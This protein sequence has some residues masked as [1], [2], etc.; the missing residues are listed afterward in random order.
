MSNSPLQFKLVSSLQK[1]FSK[2]TPKEMLKR[3]FSVLRGEC[4]SFQIAYFSKAL[5]YSLEDYPVS[6]E[7]QGD[8][9]KDFVYHIVSEVPSH[10]PVHALEDIDDNYLKTEVGLYPDALIP[11]SPRFGKAEGIKDGQCLKLTAPFQHW[12]S[13]WFELPVGEQK[14]GEHSL[15]L[16][17]KDKEQKII[18]QDTLVL[19]IIDKKLVDLDIVHTEW[20]HSDCLADYYEV[21][22]F[23]ERHWEII[24]NYMKTAA[25]HGINAVLTPIFTL[26]LDTQVGGERTTH[27]L[28]EVT[29]K[30]SGYH[31]D[32]SKLDR[33]TDLALRCGIKY[34][35][36]AHLFTQWGAKAAPK[37][38]A[39]VDGQI[40]KIF[41]WETPATS[42]EY[43]A[44]LRALLTDLKRWIIERG[45]EKRVIF[46]I[47]DEP[48]ENDK[49]CY[50]AAKNSVLDIIS[51]FFITD[52]LSDFAL[53]Q[54]G[55]VQNP[56]V[57]TDHI[58]HFIEQGAKNLWV[59][60]CCSQKNKVANRFMAMPSAR[61][62]ILGL[63]LYRFEMKGFLHWGYNF[64]NSQ[65]S[66]EQIDPYRVT[67]AGGAFPS[68]DAF[69]VY[70]A[71]DGKALPSIRLKVLAEAFYDYRALKTLEHEIGRDKVL[72]LL[73]SE[74]GSSFTFREYPREEDFLW[75]FREKVNQAIINFKL[76]F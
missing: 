6:L 21:E 46:H 73:E 67:D 20:F 61:N 43:T 5:G 52:A 11:F 31:F 9:A 36:F 45:M 27:Q 22:V 1:V 51:D 44:F 64:Y 2:E 28:V 71:K 33:W 23:G 75:D 38:V 35:E 18:W 66:L 24:E 76:D 16:C 65:Y 8:L 14:A 69:L 47:S 10:F 48:H 57:A 53:Y 62:R 40:Q 30:D 54:E 74:T 72:A 25:E 15:I 39:K 41:G 26:P 56:V 37:I 68:G 3:H 60:Y 63:Q 32:F 42:P 12:R 34:I 7:I 4:F 29:K 70:P 49:E 55:I 58:D 13:L 59:Y 50:L 17:A 19:E